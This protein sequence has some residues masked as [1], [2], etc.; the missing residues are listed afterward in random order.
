MMVCVARIM[1]LREEAHTLFMVV[2]GT[3]SGRPAP[4]AHWRAG[5]WPKLEGCQQFEREYHVW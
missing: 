5:A 1:A 4:N 2:L 3:V